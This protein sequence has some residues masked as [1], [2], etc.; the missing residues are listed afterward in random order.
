[1][2]GNKKAGKKIRGGELL[3]RALSEKG[4]R[5]VFTLAGG[6][7][8]PALEGFMERGT[9]VINCAHEQIAGHFADGHTRITREPSVCLVGPEG[10][11]NAVP[12]MMEAWGE[13]SPVIFVTGSS[14][15]K[16]SGAG[17]FK[18]VDD[19]GMA[20]RLCKESIGITDGTRIR[21]C[22]DRAWKVAMSGYVGAVHLSVPV[23]I[24]FS[25]FD[26][27]CGREERPFVTEGEGGAGAF[28][29]PCA[30]PAPEALAEVLRVI[31]AAKAPVVIAGHGVWWARAEGRLGEV[32]AELQ[33]PVFNMPYHQKLLCESNAAYCGLADVHQFAPAGF[34]LA[35]ADVVVVLGGWLDHQLNF[36]NPPLLPK[37][38]TLVCVNGSHEELVQNRA[39]DM[40]LLADP[41]AFLDALAG[42]Q[43]EGKWKLGGEWLAQN[44]RARGA[45]VEATLADL[46]K[47]GAGSKKGK[48]KG[49]VD[50]ADK[51]HPLQLAL[52]VQ[53]EM[54]AQD[55]LVFDGGNTHFWC[56]IAMNISGWQGRRFGGVLH[57][58][59]F[60]MLGCGVPFAL[61][62][63]NL[64]PKARV[65][66]LSGDGAF[67]AGGLSVEAAF[68]EGLPLV[69]VVDNNSGLVSIGQQQERLFKSGR[70]IATDFREIPFHALFVGMGGMGELVER[71]EELAGALR[72]AF[73]SA[74]AGVPACVNVRCR[75][76]I[77][78]IIR[79][80]TS[81]RDKASIE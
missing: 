69:V 6:F 36:G 52:D 28:V 54:D 74:D 19:V 71:R 27:A 7:F 70:R 21:E 81:K 57:P 32:C 53:G 31:A 76:A 66:L 63:K 44:R 73:A 47:G 9:K 45:W 30:W 12:A 39:A 60:S 80:V 18:E 79:A 5:Y 26:E 41:S 11:A 62:A 17:G 46:Q 65:V 8:N 4:V 67:L 10:F 50:E 77:S 13:R 15:L 49:G 23:D 3:A 64:H 25:S 68:Q 55:W 1:M 58:G 72:R 48:A 43:G 37:S 75:G 51:I 35:K 59:A 34:A 22:V 29:S 38:A 20:A 14:T 2:T 16:R 61:A 24:M 40:V 78:P 33:I 56:E 42:L